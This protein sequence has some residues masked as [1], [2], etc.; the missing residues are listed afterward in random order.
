MFCLKEERRWK[1][2]SQRQ[3]AR[4]AKRAVI[5][6]FVAEMSSDFCFCPPDIW[7][8]VIGPFL[9]GHS[10]TIENSSA[11]GSFLYKFYE[12]CQKSSSYLSPDGIPNAVPTL[13]KALSFE[14]TIFPELVS[15]N[16]PVCSE[17]FRSR[18]RV[19][20][21]RGF[22]CYGSIYVFRVTWS[23]EKADS[24]CRLCNNCK[25]VQC[26]VVDCSVLGNSGCPCGNNLPLHWHSPWKTS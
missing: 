15:E 5:G 22:L 14:R 24:S 11:N 21:P 18:S 7:R 12:H 3:V 16:R 20:H 23:T 25:L 6:A 4:V 17:R 8:P 26:C 13:W 9:S 10:Q 19:V 1:I 2:I